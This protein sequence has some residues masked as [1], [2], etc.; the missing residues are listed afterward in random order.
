MF[1]LPGRGCCAC[2]CHRLHNLSSQSCPWW[3]KTGLLSP[4]LFPHHSIQTWNIP[5]RR[6]MAA[7]AQ[8]EACSPNT[9]GDSTPTRPGG[10]T[11]VREGGGEGWGHDA[12]YRFVLS[13]CRKYS[14]WVQDSLVFEPM[15]WWIKTDCMWYATKMSKKTM[16]MLYLHQHLSRTGLWFKV[17]FA[18]NVCSIGCPHVSAVSGNRL[19]M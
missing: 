3:C 19:C 17:G 11:V 12:N 6:P 18:E 13:W 16:Y 1:L 10:A 2:T 14:L 8:T 5:C 15:M 7:G 9:G 4:H